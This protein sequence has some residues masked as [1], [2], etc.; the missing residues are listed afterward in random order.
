MNELE[1]FHSLLKRAIYILKFKDKNLAESW[2]NQ[3]NTNLKSE[4][5][6]SCLVAAV[7][8]LSVTD[9]D[10]FHWV[11]DNL[12]DW[13]T[14]AHLLENVTKFIIQKLIKKGFVPGKD[15]SST[16]EGKILIHKKARTAIMSDI[17]ETDNL[18]ITKILRIS[19]QIHFSTKS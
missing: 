16:L 8:E 1:Q 11:I 19:P 4:S 10:T 5:I 12:S 7:F 6:E 13:H 2:R 14:Y 18:L 15:F 17:S 3:L 9:I